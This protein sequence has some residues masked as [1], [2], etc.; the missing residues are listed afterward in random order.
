M[1]LLS[2]LTTLDLR[3]NNLST[4]PDSFIDLHNLKKLDLRWNSFSEVPY[5]VFILMERGC[6]VHM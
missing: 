6:L 5:G 2:E 4:L 1:W 3:A